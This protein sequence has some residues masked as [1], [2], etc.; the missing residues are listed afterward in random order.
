[1]EEE[2]APIDLLSKMTLCRPALGAG[3]HTCDAKSCISVY[4]DIPLVKWLSVTFQRE[5]TDDT[6]PFHNSKQLI[7]HCSCSF[8]KLFGPMVSIRVRVLQ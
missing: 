6:I 4:Y 1:M 8:N 3:V 5:M 2:E 7:V